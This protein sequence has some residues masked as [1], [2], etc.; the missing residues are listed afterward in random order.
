[1]KHICLVTLVE[2]IFRCLWSLEE[3]MCVSVDMRG[4]RTCECLRR[5]CQHIVLD[6]IAFM[7]RRAFIDVLNRAFFFAKNRKRKEQQFFPQT[8]YDLCGLIQIGLERKF[9]CRFFWCR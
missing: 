8:N 5:K 1:M 7:I 2:F 6:S 4:W 3:F 9:Y